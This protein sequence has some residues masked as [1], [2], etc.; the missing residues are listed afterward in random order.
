[1]NLKKYNRKT[2]LFAGSGDQYS[3]GLGGEEGLGQVQKMLQFQ[4]NIPHVFVYF[5]YQIIS[6]LE[7]LI[8]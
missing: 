4:E 5:L 7:H 6:L 8:P 3:I 2:V 1:M